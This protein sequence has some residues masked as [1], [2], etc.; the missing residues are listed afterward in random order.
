MSSL[1]LDEWLRELGGEIPTH[2]AKP[3]F[4]LP[5][6]FSRS[7]VR[8]ILGCPLLTAAESLALRI[9]AASGIHAEELTGMTPEGNRIRISGERE[10]WV[11]LDPDTAKALGEYAQ[12]FPWGPQELRE[13]LI[14]AAT[15]A[16]K[17]SICRVQRAATCRQRSLRASR[18]SRI[19]ACCS[20]STL[21]NCSLQLSFDGGGGGSPAVGFVAA[22]SGSALRKESGAADGPTQRASSA[23]ASIEM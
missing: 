3:Y 2:S 6:I 7:E 12:P 17:V 10:R 9:L 20:C 8:Q 13:I 1:K 16:C 5:L 14:K 4:V 18:N 21:A 23:K 15:W 19:R 11:E 22:A